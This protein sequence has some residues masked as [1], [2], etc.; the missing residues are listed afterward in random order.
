MTTKS[1]TYLV[2]T[3]M[4]LPLIISLFIDNFIVAD[5]GWKG[6][7]TFLTLVN[8]LP[9]ILAIGAFTTFTTRNSANPEK[10]W[11][12]GFGIP[13]VI[14]SLFIISTVFP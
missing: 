11:W 7:G 3:A 13:S 1:K 14:A 5:S 4:S 6:V 12:I 9:L 8:Y 10:W 2:L